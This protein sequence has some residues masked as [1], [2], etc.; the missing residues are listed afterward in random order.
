MKTHRTGYRHLCYF[1]CSLTRDRSKLELCSPD[2][3]GQGQGQLESMSL[4][5][6]QRELQ[7]SSGV[8]WTLSTSH[9]PVNSHRAVLPVPVASSAG[10]AVCWTAAMTWHNASALPI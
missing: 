8:T 4:F 6:C 5:R 3:Q 2:S 7:G 1:F 10:L 9:K